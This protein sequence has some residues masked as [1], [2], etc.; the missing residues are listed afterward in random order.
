MYM[1]IISYFGDKSPKTLQPSGF[2]PFAVFVI[3]KREDRCDASTDK[4]E[5]CETD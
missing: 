5:V 2:Y 4:L 3:W 1:D